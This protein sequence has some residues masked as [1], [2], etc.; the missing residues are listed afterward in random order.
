MLKM[1]DLTQEG[2]VN[3]TELQLMP[4]MLKYLAGN[5]LLSAIYFEMYIIK[6]GLK[7]GWRHGQMDTYVD[8]FSIA[9]Y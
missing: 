7:N 2:T 1:K 5:V 8:K 3:K 9:K 4:C 6:D